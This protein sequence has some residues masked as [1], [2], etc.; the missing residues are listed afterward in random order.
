M[1]STEIF[2]EIAKTLEN[3]E[4][5]IER[6][7]LLDPKDKEKAAK[8]IKE[9]KKNFLELSNEST[10]EN[11][12][13]ANFFL[14]RAIL[15]KNSTTDKNIEKI[16]KKA[17]MQSVDEILKFSRVAKYEFTDRIKEVFKGYRIY[18]LGMIFFFML[19]GV[20][21]PSFKMVAFFLLIPVLLS[22]WT[23]KKRRYLALMSAFILIPLPII[24]GILAIGNS[25]Y[26]ITNPVMLQEIAK[27][28]AKSLTFVRALLILTIVLGALEVVSLSYAAYSLYK[29]RH[30]FL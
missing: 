2:K 23:L 8:K 27:S 20:L 9:A 4:E 30:A 28:M 21:S 19:C 26:T 17:Y 24:T 5:R 14:R 10:A 11:E 1:K 25:I 3:V 6:L 22:L 12:K 13:L 15:L 7:K 18:A 16:G 29:H